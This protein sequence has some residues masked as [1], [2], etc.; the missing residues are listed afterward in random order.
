MTRRLLIS[1]SNRSKCLITSTLRLSSVGSGV[2]ELCQ[3]LRRES[4]TSYPIALW[5]QNCSFYFAENLEF[6]FFV[7]YFLILFSDRTSVTLQ[8]TFKL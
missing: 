8:C 5:R 7:N 1:V 4:G 2:F 6:L 3:L